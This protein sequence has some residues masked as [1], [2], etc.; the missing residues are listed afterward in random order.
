MI[1]NRILKTA[2]CCSGEVFVVASEEDDEPCLC[3]VVTDNSAFSGD[4]AAV[5]DPMD[6]SSNIDSGL[7]TGSIIGVY[8]QPKYSQPDVSATV[9][10]KGSELIFACYCLYSASTHLVCTLR[11]GV[12]QFTL[13]DVSGEFYLTQ[14]N[15]QIP[16]SGPIYSFNDANSEKWDPKVRQYLTDFKS[17]GTGKPVARYMGA[18]VAD[19]HNIMRKGGIFGYP[20]ESNKPKGKLRLLYE[21]NPIALI[22]EQ[23]GG[24]ASS[25]TQRILDIP[26]TSV[27]QR[28]PLFLGSRDNVLA[29]EEAVKDT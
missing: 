27:H 8:K 24:R 11:S 20:G 17:A 13:D 10:Q 6:G 4:Y 21:A 18:L 15:I 23:A 25:G 5:F 16:T 19:I 2:L 7:P 3:S 14:S 1:A 12:H 29:L 26:V 22:L 9:L 28:T